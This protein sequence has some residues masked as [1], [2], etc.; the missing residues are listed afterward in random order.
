MKYLITY[1]Q[2]QLVMH[3][4]KTPFDVYTVFKNTKWFA[5]RNTVLAYSIK[6]NLK[7]CSP[8]VE[9]MATNEII[10]LGLIFVL[11]LNTWSLTKS[12]Y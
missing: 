10:I 12:I 6:S 2:L 3:E 7:V 5:L 4:T 11:K 8:K 1:S 9:H